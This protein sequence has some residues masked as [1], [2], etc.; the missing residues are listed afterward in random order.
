MSEVKFCEGMK[1]LKNIEK[2]SIDLVLTDPPYS[3]F[4][5]LI[6]KFVRIIPLIFSIS[7]N[8]FSDL[9]TFPVPIDQT[10]S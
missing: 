10:G 9:R 6:L 1:Y 5:S 2:S 8:K 4:I 7:L 3:I